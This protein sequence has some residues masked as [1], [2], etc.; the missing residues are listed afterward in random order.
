MLGTAASIRRVIQALKPHNAALAPI[1][2]PAATTHSTAIARSSASLLL[3]IRPVL[4]KT[5]AI[6]HTL[7]FNYVR[8]RFVRRTNRT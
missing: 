3:A 7:D 5:S 8:K 4:V 6:V 2:T 1:N